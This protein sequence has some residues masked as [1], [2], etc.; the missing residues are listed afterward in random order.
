MAREEKADFIVVPDDQPPVLSG[1]HLEPRLKQLARNVRIYSQDR[2]LDTQSVLQR[3]KDAEVVINI[4]A[5][6]R[7][8]RDVLVQCPKLKLVSVWGIGYDNI[9]T[10]ACKELGITVTNTPG[11]ASIGVAEHAL[12]LMLAVARQLVTNDRAIREGRWARGWLTQLH[13]K[14]LGVVGT[15]PIGQQMVRLGKGIGMK[16]IAWTFHPSPQRAREYGVEFVSL[17]ELLRQSDVVSL[18]VP[19]TKDTEKLVGREQLAFMRPNAILVNT[20]RGPVVDEQALYEFLRDKRIAGAGIDVFGTEP[21]PKGHPFTT[22]DNLVLSP[23]VA[24]MS[25]ETTLA[26]IAMSLDNIEN[27]LKG[28]PTHVVVRGIR[29]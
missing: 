15:G 20:A 16:V 22:L 17:E 4:R 25:P 29:S 26:G 10:A 21:L 11:Y 9:D 24:P 13:S 1:T 18:H 28:E 12:A 3:I 5:S 23:H 7:F 6:T 14:T 8:S 19:L 27:F 2:P